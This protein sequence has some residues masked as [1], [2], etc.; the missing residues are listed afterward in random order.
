MKL[1]TRKFRKD[2][3]GFSLIEMIC[4]V[5]ILGAISTAIGGAMVVSSNSYQRGTTETAIQQ[6]S[7]FTANVIE[8]LIVDATDEVNFNGSTKTLEIKN[9]DYT[10][11]INLDT[12]TNTL[13]YTCTDKNTGALVS[14][15]SVLASDVEDFN[16]D[17]TNFTE[18]RNAQITIKMKRDNSEIGTVYNVTSRNNPGSSIAASFLPSAIISGPSEITLEPNQE[19]TFN[20][21]VTATGGASNAVHG[22]LTGNST[23]DTKVTVNATYTEVTVEL[24]AHEYGTGGQFV[25]ALQSSTGD[26]HNVTINVRRVN[27]FDMS[28]ITLVS[29]TAFKK[30]AVYTVSA[31]PVGTHLDKSWA[32][33]STY[34]A[35]YKNPYGA[36]FSFEASAG[37]WSDYVDVVDTQEENDPSV[38]FKLKEDMGETDTIKVTARAKHPDGIVN[39]VQTNKTGE[40]YDAVT[41]TKILKKTAFASSPFLR[42]S[43]V[44]MQ[45]TTAIPWGDI[46]SAYGGNAPYNQIRFR[47]AVLDAA[48]NFVSWVPGEDWGEWQDVTDHGTAGDNHVFIRPGDYSL[49]PHYA[50]AAELKLRYG[51][52]A[53]DIT[54]P[55]EGTTPQADYLFEF[56][57]PRT[58]I[59]LNGCYDYPGGTFP[60]GCLGTDAGNPLIFKG[61]NTVYWIDATANATHSDKFMQNNLSYELVNMNTGLPASLQEFGMSATNT[62][63]FTLKMKMPL[64]SSTTPSGTLYKLTLKWRDGL[65]FDKGFGET[66]QPIANETTGEGI[67]YIR[68]M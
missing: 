29:G 18:S 31:R 8:S 39:G 27:S 58:T 64:V 26:I 59:Q 6:D 2:T 28:E 40:I 47:P 63:H 3:R 65:Y 52:S 55:I 34:D 20:I 50:Y 43:D 37:L 49:A 12:A 33:A 15:T 45:F 66:N 38:I 46:K 4:A 30:D 1:F 22:S 24:G 56:Y 42:G 14:P 36:T 54:W 32:G 23:P 67:F 5:A 11:T 25:V 19:Y 62:E 21:G 48:G 51:N 9:I 53:T 10:H 13:Y 7:H 16:V 35:D 68:V 61:D 17:A 41:M 44:D 57:I 60:I